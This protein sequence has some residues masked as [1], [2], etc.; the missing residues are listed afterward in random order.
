[1]P[2]SPL[3]VPQPLLIYG[4]SSA[5]GMLGVQFAVMSG[6]RVITTS[7]PHNFEYLRSLGASETFDYNS[8][9][10][11]E[12]INKA[13][14]G[15][16]KLAWDCISSKASAEFCARAL[17]AEGGDYGALLMVDDETLTS[18]NPKVRRHLTF[19]Y[20]IFGREFQ[21]AVP[22][23][24]KNVTV[25]PIPANLQDLEFGKMFWELAR[26]LFEHGKIKPIKLAINRGGS[27]LEGVLRGLQD[28]REGKV[29][30]AKL[31]YT[32]P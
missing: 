9:N 26:D 17:S 23:F 21:M 30:G 7:S 6:Y 22:Y 31:V 15:Q 27:G 4:A 29:S 28:M 2:T 5:T 24:G 16:L 10:S 18:V 12:E 3:H 19:Y 32:L 13:T 1:M 8:P 14:N 20:T 11:A 25:P